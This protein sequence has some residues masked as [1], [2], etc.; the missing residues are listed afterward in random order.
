MINNDRELAVTKH[1]LQVFKKN[2]EDINNLGEHRRLVALQKAALS[3]WIKQFK[4]DIQEYER[5]D[6]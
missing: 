3:S 2:L 6:R 5:S 1:W 4:E